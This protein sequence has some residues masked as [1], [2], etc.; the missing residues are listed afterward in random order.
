MLCNGRTCL[1]FKWNNEI[2]LLNPLDVYIQS[3][4]NRETVN[5]DVVFVGF[6]VLNLTCF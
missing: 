4:V 1:M 3:A 2:C 6:F 5:D